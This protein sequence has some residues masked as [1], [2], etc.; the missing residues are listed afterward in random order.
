MRYRNPIGIFLIIALLFL[1]YGLSVLAAEI[2]ACPTPGTGL[3]D[4]IR[5]E[6]WVLSGFLRS[7]VRTDQTRGTG[8]ISLGPGSWIEVEGPEASLLSIRPAAISLFFYERNRLTDEIMD[9][10]LDGLDPADSGDFYLH[11]TEEGRVIDLLKGEG[12]DFVL[13]VNRDYL[14]RLGI[15][16]E[17]LSE[18][19]SVHGPLEWRVLGP[20]L[21]MARVKAFRFV[22]LGQNE[23]VILR[24]DPMFHDLRPFYFSE[25]GDR[26]LRMAEW[27]ALIPEASALFNAGLY[28]PGNKP[29]GLFLT[30]GKNHGTGLHS[31]WEGLLASGGPAE[32]PEVPPS[33]ILDLRF[34]PFFPENTPYRFALQSFMILDR[35]GRTRVR[36]TGN[37]ASRTILAQDRSG[38]LLVI[39]VPGAIALFEMAG[40]LK[41]SELDVLQAMCLDGGFESQLFIR[42]APQDLYFSGAFVVNDQRQRYQEGLRL[43]LP[44]VIG[45]MPRS[46]RP[47]AVAP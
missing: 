21:E 10:G 26:P 42:S 28:L 5:C 14:S 20:G 17:A 15:T 7:Q 3:F 39:I 41:M 25:G 38:K 31:R 30:D 29:L 46:P 27:A 4:D 34:S 13:G 6:L 32:R 1:N 8:P 16:L 44:A 2:A 45:V 35:E 24:I 22:R 12:D 40:F 19:R 37:L 23:M 18:R 33:Q 36:R 47:P 11:Y 9:R 43:P